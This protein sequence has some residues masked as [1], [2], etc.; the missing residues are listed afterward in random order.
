MLK[1]AQAVFRQHTVLLSKRNQIR[2]CAHGDQIQIVPQFDP[3][4]DGMVLRPEQLDQPVHELEHES[5]RA[6]IPPSLISRLVVSV[7]VDEKTILRRQPLSGAVMVNDD[8]L[9]SLSSKVRDLIVRVRP[10]IDS[11]KKSGDALFERAIDGA[12]REPVAILGAA[13]NDEARI[14]T[15]TSQDADQQ[16]GAG[17]AVHIIV[18]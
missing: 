9:Y 10:A 6:E 16:G 13:R 17:D 3:K 12:S 15:E 2:D 11:D 5:H 8:D 7:G 18:P 4:G 1:D 14:E